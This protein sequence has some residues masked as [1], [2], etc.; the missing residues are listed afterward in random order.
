[1]TGRRRS[2]GQPFVPAA[3][4]ALAASVL[5]GM[6]SGPARGSDPLRDEPAAPAETSARGAGIPVPLSAVMNRRALLAREQA[7]AAAR[8]AAA[9]RDRVERAMARPTIIESEAVRRAGGSGLSFTELTP[10]GE[11]RALDGGFSVAPAPARPGPGTVGRVDD[12]FARAQAQFSRAAMA[13]TGALPAD[14][15]LARAQAEFSRAALADTGASAA[16]AGLSR[17]LARF[18]RTAEA[19]TGTTA[20]DEGLGRAQRQ[21]SRAALA[22]TGALPADAGLSRAQ[23]R[24]FRSALAGTGV[25]PAD[26][27]WRRAQRHYA[28]SAGAQAATPADAGLSRAQAQYHRS[29]LGRAIVIPRSP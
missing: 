19:D 8:D 23:A 20:A 17:A 7:D 10:P 14:A 3:R 6:A 28:R 27:G 29:A 13:G 18:A 22:N 2:L 9:E 12:G 24:Y 5:L 4:A 1:M 16:D 21:F 25:T 26:E 15:G 11:R